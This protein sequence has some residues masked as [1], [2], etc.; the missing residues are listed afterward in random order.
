MFCVFTRS[1]I[2]NVTVSRA[3]LRW[4]HPVLQSE[5]PDESSHMSAGVVDAESLLDQLLN[6][7]VSPEFGFITVGYGAAFQCRP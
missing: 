6:I 7:P 3:Q 4:S 2:N 5:L 1:T